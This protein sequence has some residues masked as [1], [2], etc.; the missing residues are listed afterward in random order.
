MKTIL[1]E[2]DPYNI[3]DEIISIA[4]QFLKDGKLVSFPTE[5]VYGLGANGLN[6]E[7]CLNIYKAKGRPSDNPLILHISNL[8]QLDLLT[9]NISE[10]AKK[11]MKAFW[12]AP[13]TLV[14]KKSDLVS[15]VVSG[16]LDTVAVRFPK[17]PVAQAL[18]EKA[19]V[20]IAAP[21]ANLSGKP[22]CTKASHV[23]ADLFG[24]ID[25]II[26][27]GH[28][29]IGL[30][31]TILDTT[32]TPP[33]ILRPG[34]VTIEEIENVIGKVDIDK[35]LMGKMERNVVPKA[36]GMKY[37]HYSPEADVVL[38]NYSKS[39]FNNHEDYVE[40]VNILIS[41]HQKNNKKVGVL[42]TEKDVNLYNCDVALSL[43]DDCNL[44]EIGA[45]LFSFLREM[46]SFNVD[47][48]F[49]QTFSE[50]KEGFAIMNR[51][52]KASGYNVIEV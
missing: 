27:G 10:T 33:T 1:S 20:P 21:S 17:N 30:E 11:I 24:K 47:I 44:E 25:M 40:K 26:D 37:I 43:G 34:F 52:K 39:L 42:A 4:G 18:I 2:I 3:D 22:S 14:F 49:V 9:K 46:D 8:S 45:N 29:S 13:L 15:N 12:P 41:E 50:E 16:G 23:V 48:I 36:P 38:I 32:T 28:C 6:E 31:S 51:L 19:G 5:T 35:T 7:A